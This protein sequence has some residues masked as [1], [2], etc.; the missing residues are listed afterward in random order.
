MRSIPVLIVA[1]ALLAI[2][3]GC[4]VQD[5]RPKVVLTEH[6]RDSVLAT[7]KVIPGSAG[8]GAA[9]RMSDRE[10]ARAA[11]MNAAVDSLPR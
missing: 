3:A 10:A 2:T 5:N 8:V 11:G 4:G 7:E 1:I 6:Q 9:L